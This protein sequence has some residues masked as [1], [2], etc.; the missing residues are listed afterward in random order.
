MC[1]ALLRM[2]QPRNGRS[3]TT[4]IRA[5][6]DVVRPARDRRR[7]G[8]GPF[9]QHHEWHVR[10][11]LSSSTRDPAEAPAASAQTSHAPPGLRHRR[12]RIDAAPAWLVSGAASCADH[13]R[14]T[15]A[16]AIRADEGVRP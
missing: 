13:E 2:A 5:A 12:R 6:D 3:E 1:A 8:I 16:V 15:V 7:T 14:V 10:L 9:G 4:Q 11:R